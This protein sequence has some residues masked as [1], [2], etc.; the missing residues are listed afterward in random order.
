MTNPII[1]DAVENAFVPLLIH[2]NTGGEDAR[3][4]KK[5]K[6]PSWNYQVVR[7]LDAKGGDIIP[8]KA[9]V[10]TQGELT[11]RMVQALEKAKQP[12][13][14]SLALLKSSLEVNQ[15]EQAAF[16]CHCF[17]TGEHKLGALDG[18]VAT[19][20]GWLDGREV[21]LVTYHRGEISLERLVKSAREMQVANDVYLGNGAQRAQVSQLVKSP[22]SLQGYRKAKASDQKRQISGTAFARLELSPTQACKVNAFCRGNTSEAVKYLTSAQL[23]KISK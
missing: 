14:K 7:F 17:W 6:E 20:A 4:L 10:N 18:V 21:T 9:Q 13:P 22:K 5:Y 2:N 3:I 12:V 8:R 23:A 19:E 11:A 16:S 15:L 1:I